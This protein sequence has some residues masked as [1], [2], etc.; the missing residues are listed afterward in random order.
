MSFCPSNHT[1]W[2]DEPD[3]VE[4]AERWL[5]EYPEEETDQDSRLSW[6]R[7][8]IEGLLDCI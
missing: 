1:P 7:G 2:D 5:E 4:E 6:A 8:I 3:P